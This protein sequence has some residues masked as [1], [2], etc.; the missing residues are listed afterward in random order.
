VMPTRNRRR[1]RVLE[2]PEWSADTRRARC[3]RCLCG[4]MLDV[5]EL[6]TAAMA[7]TLGSGRRRHFRGEEEG[8]IGGNEAVALGEPAVAGVD[9]HNGVLKV[10]MA[11]APERRP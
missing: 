4:T 3:S 7:C 8:E 2:M 5:R 10:R 9:G 11:G 6:G 1:A